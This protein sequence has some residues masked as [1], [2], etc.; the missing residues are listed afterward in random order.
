MGFPLSRGRGRIPRGC[1]QEGAH[2]KIA[3]NGFL[4]QTHGDYDKAIDAYSESLALADDTSMRCVKLLSNVGTLCNDMRQHERALEYL[5]QARE[6]YE[7]CW[8]FSL[9]PL[10]CF[11]SSCD[12]LRR[13]SARS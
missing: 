9:S 4:H 11:S 12:G 7:A 8:A 10:R 2:Q 13:P 3:T 6:T 1:S 5:E